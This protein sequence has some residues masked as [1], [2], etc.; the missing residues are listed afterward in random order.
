MKA[1]TLAREEIEGWRENIDQLMG[2]SKEDTM[3][4]VTWR[5]NAWRRAYELSPHRKGI[6]DSSM[7]CAAWWVLCSSCSIVTRTSRWTTIA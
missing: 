7:L 4:S 1:H 3:S 2:G 6:R 5:W